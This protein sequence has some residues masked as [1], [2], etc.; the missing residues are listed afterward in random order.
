MTNDRITQDEFLK[1]VQKQRSLIRKLLAGEKR[2]NEILTELARQRYG[3]M[4]GKFFYTFEDWRELNKDMRFCVKDFK[5]NAKNVYNDE[6]EVQMLCTAVIAKFDSKTAKVDRIVCCDY[7]VRFNPDDDLEKELASMWIGWEAVDRSLFDWFESLRLCCG[8]TYDSILKDALDMVSLLQAELKA[9]EEAHRA[10]MKGMVK[11]TGM[12][13]SHLREKLR[14]DY[15]Q[16]N[17]MIAWASR[18]DHPLEGDGLIMVNE[19]AESI[20]SLIKK[21]LGV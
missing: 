7:T 1:G 11:W 19:S 17:N 12:V 14:E 21:E 18:S 9:M 5:A 6:V 13:E 3:W 8:L 16:A 20:I 4:K 10:E 2:R 15:T